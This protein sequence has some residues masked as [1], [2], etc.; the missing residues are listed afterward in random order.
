MPQSPFTRY[1]VFASAILCISGCIADLLMI[2]IFGNQIP[3]FNQLTGTLSSLGVSTSP[4]AGEVTVWSV[5]LGIVLIFF[6]MG[7]RQ[8][9]Q[10]YG[11]ETRNA[12]WL[13]IFY[14]LGEDIASGIF[15]ADS[16]NGK[17][18]NLAYLHDVLG[19][20][21]V[22]SLLILP[23]VMHQ[24]FTKFSFPLFN[25]YSRMAW[26]AGIIAT[27]LFSFRLEYFAG[28]FLYTYSGLWQR[29]FLVNYY[30]YFIV[31]SFMIM[32]ET[33]ISRLKTHKIS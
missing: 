17:L 22:V 2:W 19:G 7:F 20:I 11:K 1:L 29:I 28:T 4:V 13:I 10:K 26:F 24:I 23:L 27:L 16:I 9:F 12:F 30:I 25:R 21:G 6:A 5:V 8:A 31:I 3:G 15:R 32:K 18:T 14:A 33:N